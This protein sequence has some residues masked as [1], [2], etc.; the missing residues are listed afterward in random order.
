MHKTAVEGIEIVAVKKRVTLVSSRPRLKPP[1]VTPKQPDAPVVAAAAASQKPLLGD[2]EHGSASPLQQEGTSEPGGTATPESHVP[3]T[4]DGGTR[5]APAQSSPHADV[6]TPAQR[7][8]EDAVSPAADQPRSSPP[9]G[10][11]AASESQP[12]PGT[13]S[14]NDSLGHPVDTGTTKSEPACVQP[15]GPALPGSPAA[16]PERA[17]L[18]AVSAAQAIGSGAALKEGD[19]AM[20]AVHPAPKPDAVK[21]EA[22]SS[23]PDGKAGTAEEAALDEVQPA[24]DS[25]AAPEAATQIQPATGADGEAEGTDAPLPSI[26]AATTL[27]AAKADPSALGVTH[28]APG[29]AVP[30]STAGTQRLPAEPFAGRDAHDPVWQVSH[31]PLQVQSTVQCCNQIA[32]LTTIGKTD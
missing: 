23:A 32:E 29:T 28:G 18:S 21:L 19:D 2:A 4:S 12:Q 26:A 15:S 8:A 10:P 14:A 25:A 16:V 22:G 30:M 9:G 20:A 31:V 17:P 7:Q 6:S 13:L 3:A 11:E 5:T 1:L 24:S 27:T